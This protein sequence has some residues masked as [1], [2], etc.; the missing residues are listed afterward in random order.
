MDGLSTFDRITSLITVGDVATPVGAVVP[1]DASI[2]Q[3]FSLAMDHS[4]DSGRDFMEEI[5]LV[6]NQCG[7]V[8]GYILP[9][10]LSGDTESIESLVERFTPSQI[11]SS[12]TPLLNAIGLLG[13][14]EGYF[15]F[16]NK[17]N[18]I[19]AT[20]FGD[21]LYTPLGRL[22]LLAL[23]LE[24]EAVALDVC[25]RDAER[26]WNSLNDYRKT[27][28]REIRDRHHGNQRPRCESAWSLL[29]STHFCDKGTMLQKLGVLPDF[30]SVKVIRKAKQ[31]RDF[32]AHPTGDAQKHP[33]P[34][35]ELPQVVGECRKLIESLRSLT[36]RTA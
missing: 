8:I 30:K 25:Q 24:L 28:A 31:L 4:Y 16:V 12:D 3:A 32:C 18:R 5:I 7:D 6:E 21:D 2:E 10:H 9:D 26:A 15:F 19:V 23:T 33:I 35:G 34:P 36:N 27:K 13:E 20:F 29:N 1:E 17:A 22:G 11:V 14:S